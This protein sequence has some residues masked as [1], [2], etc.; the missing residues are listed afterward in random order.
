MQVILVSWPAT[1]Y[2]FWRQ[3]IYGLAITM[4][5]SQYPVAREPIAAGTPLTYNGKI[6]IYSQSFQRV[7]CVFASEAASGIVS[8]WNPQLHKALNYLLTPT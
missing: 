5:Y 3:E 2:E 7:F 6:D 1:C 8:L 4:A